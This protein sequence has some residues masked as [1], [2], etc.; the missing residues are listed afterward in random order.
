MTDAS[1][2]SPAPTLRMSASDW[3]LLLLLSVLWGG[4]FFFNRVALDAL[5]PL[6]VGALRVGLAAAALLAGMAAM[7][8]RLR[9]DA[10]T[11]RA[12]AGMGFLNNV[13]P[14][15]LI[16][17]AQTRLPSGVASILNATTPLFT[18]IVA[19]WLTRD[20]RLTPARAS[21]AA[22][23]FLG[24]AAMMGLGGV[25]AARADGP[26]IAACLVAA[27]SYALSGVYGRRFRAMGVPPLSTAAG[28][29]SA[30]ALL[31]A[32][33]ALLVDRPWTLPMPGATAL[34]AVAGLALISTA[35]A[36]LIFFRI[37]ARAGATNILLV[38]FLIPPSA[39]L[40]GVVFLN[41]TLAARHFLGMAMIGLGLAAIDGRPLAALTPSR[42]R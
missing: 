36:Y 1:S 16:L 41:E 9:L 7:G 6:T 28:Q 27:L 22:L 15:A 29:L 8:A 18:V 21:G 24:V 33:A 38:T 20:E 14:F 2:A 37:L 31:F 19:H 39:I 40:L 3:A 23:G 25:A 42:K 30:S 17:W 26:A 35:L 10:P 5:P 32:P 12:Y 13:V 11:L 4:S 34:A